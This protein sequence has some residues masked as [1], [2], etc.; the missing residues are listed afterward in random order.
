MFTK[1][2]GPKQ[3]NPYV[4]LLHIQSNTQKNTDIIAFN[5]HLK[6]IEKKKYVRL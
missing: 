5:S 4:I 1:K 2:S 3:K 6:F